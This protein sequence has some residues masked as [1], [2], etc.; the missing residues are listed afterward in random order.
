MLSTVVEKQR[1]RHA[2][3]RV[4]AAT[5]TTCRALSTVHVQQ[6]MDVA[7]YLL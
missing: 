5:R 7:T 2:A 4:V 1:G 3:L 6:S